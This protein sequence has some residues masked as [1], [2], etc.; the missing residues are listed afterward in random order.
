MQSIILNPE[1]TE[2]HVDLMLMWFSVIKI[3]A[4]NIFIFY[5]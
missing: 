3:I 5:I 2:S 4:D 1:G